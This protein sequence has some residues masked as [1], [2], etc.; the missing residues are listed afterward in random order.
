[1]LHKVLL[2]SSPK[3]FR[4]SIGA[5]TYC[6]ASVNKSSAMPGDL[7]TVTVH[8]NTGYGNVTV[9]VSPS[10]EVTKVNETTFTFV[11]PFTD[12]VVSASAMQYKTTWVTVNA[13]V[14]G[15]NDDT[16]VTIKYYY[17][18]WEE[19]FTSQSGNGGFWMDTKTKAIVTS[20][21]D[22][23]T[24]SLEAYTE[25][26]DNRKIDDRTAWFSANGSLHNSKIRL[27]FIKIDS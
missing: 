3:E 14:L 8:A 11:M 16:P 20:T 5:Q 7:V 23:Y 13:L 24:M 2:L 10:I 26:I 1:M 6:T 17:E 15:G 9:A 12:V 19:T 4:I 22:M 27:T 21:N 25:D 18:G